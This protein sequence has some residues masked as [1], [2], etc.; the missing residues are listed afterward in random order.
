MNAKKVIRKLGFNY[1]A[2][3]AF[4]MPHLRFMTYD[5][6]LIVKT[7]YLVCES[8]TI[9]QGGKMILKIQNNDSFAFFN[10]SYLEVFLLHWITESKITVHPPNLDLLISHFKEEENNCLRDFL[11]D[12]IRY[13]RISETPDV[14]TRPTKENKTTLDDIQNK[15]KLTGENDREPYSVNTF[16]DDRSEAYDVKKE[17]A[18]Y[19]FIINQ[20]KFYRESDSS[21]KEYL[22]EETLSDRTG[23]D[24]DK[25]R[26]IAVFEQ[27]GYKV[28][29]RK[30]LRHDEILK[31]IDEAAK[32]SF[33]YDSLII[34][35]LSHGFKDHV[36][37]SNSLP[38]RI[39]RIKETIMEYPSLVGKPKIL[40]VQACQGT[41][42]QKPVS[43]CF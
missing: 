10:H 29:E 27:F 20:T 40:L 39:D 17:S 31:E 32:R 34:C 3:K 41:K 26:L 33:I 7:L 13:N 1:E 18:G 25:E 14:T 30:D 35:I 38:F 9:A 6:N 4:F 11:L 36:Y 12:A 24:K 16:T 19:L 28:E 43:F 22:P 2:L 8:M 15:E 21:L 23:T 42:R 5:I 37:G